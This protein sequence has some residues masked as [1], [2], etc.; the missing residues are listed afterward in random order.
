MFNF[1]KCRRAAG[2]QQGGQN[3]MWPADSELSLFHLDEGRSVDGRR[4]FCFSSWATTRLL[5]GGGGI[6]PS[7]NTRSPTYLKCPS[8]VNDELSGLGSLMLRSVAAPCPGE[9]LAVI[10]GSASLLL[11]RMVAENGVL[12]VS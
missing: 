1:A 5:H 7:S 3:K 12:A 9:Q 6:L 10:H 2:G 11:C 4:C 8:I